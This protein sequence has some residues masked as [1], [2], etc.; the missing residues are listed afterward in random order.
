MQP[1]FTA[2]STI[3]KTQPD[4]LRGDIKIGIDC[5]VN[6]CSWPSNTVRIIISPVV[7]LVVLM[8]TPVLQNDRNIVNAIVPWQWQ[9]GFMV[10]FDNH[11]GSQTMPNLLGCGWARMRVQPQSRRR[12]F[13]CEVDMLT[14]TR[15]NR[16]M[17]SA[18][19]IRATDI[20]PMPM[21]SG[22]LRQGVF[23]CHMRMLTT[24]IHN[25]LT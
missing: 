22:Q 2:I 10:V 8:K 3:Q 6:H 23:Q 11:H 25:R 21:K 15:I 13:Q 12:L 24:A 14:F 7:P 5:T 18:I 20:S 17:A 9:A 16:R 19:N 1:P 4:L